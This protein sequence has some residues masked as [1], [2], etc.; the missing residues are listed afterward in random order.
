MAPEST[1][2]LA[3]ATSLSAKKPRPTRPDFDQH[4]QELSAI[5]AEIDKLR[6]SQDEVRDKLSKTDSR[7]GPQ[8]DKHS[9]A[10]ARLQEIRTEQ[11][12]L[13]KSRGKVFDRQAA[14][15]ASIGK[16]T[17][18]LKAQQS[19]LT[20]KTLDEIDDTIAKGEKQIESG[21][22]KIVDERRLSSEISALR[23]ARKL[24]EQANKLQKAIDSE[25]AELAEIDAQLADTNALAL[26][27]EFERLQGE[28]DALKASQDQGQQQRSSL[29][30]ERANVLKQLDQAW[31]KKRALQDEHRRQNNEYY[32][33]QQEERKRRVVEEKQQRIQEQRERRLAIAQEQRE[34]AEMPAFADEISGCDSLIIYLSG[35]LP[36]AAGACIKPESSSR[37]T[38][39]MA[40]GARDTDASM[41]IPAGMVA[42]KKTTVEEPYFAGTST[43]KSKK[44]PA[45]KD[46]RVDALKHPL[47]VAERFLDL[48]VDIPT[49][50]ASIAETI[51]K[52]SNRRRHFVETQAAATAENKRKAEEKIAKLMAELDVDEKIANGST[53]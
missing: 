27:E 46:K 2:A 11:A 47:A 48:Q 6:K 17:A 19:K 22:L 26:S 39:A 9:M 32:Q 13:R 21:S 30:N 4:R 5:D 51:E 15:T 36:S 18:E 16:K 3:A 37:P 42:V 45:R 40:S 38:A 24:V 25:V 50:S 1:A 20:F 31:E 28:L 34:E 44:K 14:L 49:T 12:E 7:K 52:L 23:R 29:F 10:L 8:A 53:H 41:H 35:I 33:W 43:V